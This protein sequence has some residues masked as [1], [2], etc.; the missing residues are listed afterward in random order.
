MDMDWNAAL[1]AQVEAHWTSQLR[2]RLDGLTDD[3]YFWEPAP[4]AWSIRRRTPTPDDKNASEFVTD[5]AVPPPEPPPVTT[6]AWRLGHLIVVVLGMRAMTRFGGPPVDFTSFPF[7][8]TANEA[9]AQ[10]DDAYQ[11]WTDGVR[12]L[13]ADGIASPAADE[14]TGGPLDEWSTADIV[15]HVHREILHHGA[16]ICL[17]RDLY[18]TQRG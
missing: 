2:P 14:T 7:A 3:E 5:F 16:E 4:G 9:L 6:I 1:R 8:G 15:L 13:G 18:R 11:A 17:L 12:A 10:L